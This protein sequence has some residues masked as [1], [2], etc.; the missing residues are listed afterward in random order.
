MKIA[1]HS[2]KKFV[3]NLQPLTM[4]KQGKK[5][6]IAQ[7]KNIYNKMPWRAPINYHKSN[8]STTTVASSSSFDEEEMLRPSESVDDENSTESLLAG[9]LSD[10]GLPGSENPEVPK[11][12]VAVYVGC[13]LRRFLIPTSCL[14]MPEFRILMDRT[15]E[16]YGFEQDGAIEIPCDEKDFQKILCRCLSSKDKKKNGKKP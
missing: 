14:S 2:T 15:A 4:I 9:K 5:H 3:S 12:Y 8:T 10:G 1:S 6:I 11:G 13:E 16:E 7:P